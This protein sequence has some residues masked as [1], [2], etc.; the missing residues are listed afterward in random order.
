MKDSP[1][2]Q[3]LAPLQAQ[4]PDHRQAQ[5]PRRS[6]QPRLRRPLLQPP[7]RRAIQLELV[8][9]DTLT[10]EAPNGRT[11]THGTT[12]GY[13]LGK[14][15]CRHCRAAYAAYRAKRRAQ[16]KDNPRN[17]RV[18]DDDPHISANWFRKHWWHPARA[19]ANLGWSPRIHDLRHA[20]ASWLLAGGADLQVVKGR[21]G[22]R[23][24]STTE[25]Y[26]PT[27]DETALEALAKIRTTPTGLPTPDTETELAEAKAKIVE[28]QAVI[29][30]QLIAQNPT[31]PRVR[32][33]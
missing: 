9:P 27:A 33:A 18:I 31:S 6:Q 4:P 5:S 17:P 14:C 19:A 8:D 24:I 32:P 1:Q 15:K 13:S 28:L 2:G 26:L 7:S 11:Y 21:L 29:A 23:K 16:G 30:E 20:H 25:R 10:F 22:H 3:A 12:T